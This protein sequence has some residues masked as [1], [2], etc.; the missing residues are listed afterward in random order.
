MPPSKLL[1]E[2]AGVHRNKLKAQQWSE[3]LLCSQGTESIPNLISIFS[4]RPSIDEP[5]LVMMNYGKNEDA[6]L[7]YASIFIYSIGCNHANASIWEF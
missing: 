5:K 7:R 4:R 1:K 3:S 6:G 2:Q